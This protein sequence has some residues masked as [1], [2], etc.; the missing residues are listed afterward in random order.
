MCRLTV[1][2]TRGNG[3]PS[4]VLIDNES[5]AKAQTVGGCLTEPFKGDEQDPGQG[6]SHDPCLDSVP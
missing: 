2:G 5:F 6:L 4:V 3:L 1:S